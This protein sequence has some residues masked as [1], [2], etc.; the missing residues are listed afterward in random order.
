MTSD[1]SEILFNGAPNNSFDTHLYWIFDKSYDTV[2]GK[3][4]ILILNS[5]FLVFHKFSLLFLNVEK[6]L[7]YNHNAPNSFKI[8]FLGTIQKP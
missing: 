8:L 5:A 7:N 1:V 3:V 6:T 2:Y 4:R